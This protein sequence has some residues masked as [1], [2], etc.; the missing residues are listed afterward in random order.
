VSIFVS[1]TGIYDT[2]HIAGCI[3]LYSP[4]YVAEGANPNALRLLSTCDEVMGY[5]AFAP[6]SSDPCIVPTSAQLATLV[7]A[8][9]N[10]QTV[11]SSCSALMLRIFLPGADASSTSAVSRQEFLNVRA[12]TA[13]NVAMFLAAG[14]PINILDALRSCPQPPPVLVSAVLQLAG[15][16]AAELNATRFGAA[17]CAAMSASARACNHE[18]GIYCRS[19]YMVAGL[20]APPR[21]GRPMSALADLMME[22]VRPDVIPHSAMSRAKGWLINKSAK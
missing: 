4:A 15:V 2:P 10:M 17:V 8:C 11:C 5:G 16:A 21:R 19:H 20:A 1:N 6:V 22:S 18:T 3:R 9:T 12:C 7:V 14:M 13:T